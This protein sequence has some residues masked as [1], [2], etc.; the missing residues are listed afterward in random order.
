MGAS[1]RGNRVLYQ[2]CMRGATV[3]ATTLYVRYLHKK[4]VNSD[5]TAGNGIHGPYC[6]ICPRVNP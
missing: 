5:I 3:A 6:H 2:E 1:L 4:P